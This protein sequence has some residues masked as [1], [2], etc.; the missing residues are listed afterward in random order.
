MSASV[1]PNIIQLYVP[2]LSRTTLAALLVVAGFTGSI[3]ADFK[4]IV[5]HPDYDHDRFG[6]H[7]TGE[8]GKTNY[9]RAFRAYVTVFD[10]EDDDNGD[11]IE[12]RL[13]IPHFVAYEIKE[14]QGTLPKGPKR[15]NTWITDKELWKKGVA[16]RDATYKYSAPFRKNHPNWY[17]RGHLCMKQHAWRLGANADWNTHTLLNA[18]PQRQEFNA[19]IWLD[20]EKLTA[21]WA[22]KYGAVWIVAGPIFQPQ[23]NTPINW[24]GEPEKGEMPVGIPNALFKIVIRKTDDRGRPKVLAF[25]YPQDVKKSEKGKPYDHEPFTTTVDA[26]EAQ[27][28]LDFLT[29]LP[30]EIEQDIEARRVTKLWPD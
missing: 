2:W 16:P 29:E 30:D 12:D 5:L 8:A 14:H 4:P 19:G 1:P 10:G 21:K 20:L 22:D 3:A 26:I 11:G 15:P 9:R 27:T 28:G 18:V 25:V 6:T 24:L 7:V 17:V 13:G 23:P